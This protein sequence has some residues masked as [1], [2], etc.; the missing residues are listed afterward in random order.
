V[1]LPT[2]AQLISLP[3]SLSG[4]RI[5]LRPYR[6]GDGRELFEAID[7]SRA[8]LTR[9]MTWPNDLRTLED[10][11]ARV[12]ILRAKWDLRED[13]ALSLRSRSTGAILGGTG[14]HRFDWTIR[15]F[16]IGY[17][18]RAD[19]ERKGYVQEACRLQ[20]ALAFRRLDATHVRVHCDARNERSAA[21]PRAMGF[22]EE[23][24]L[25]AHTLSVEGELR[26]TFVFGIT[27]D[28]F[29]AKDWAPAALACVD[30]ADHD[31]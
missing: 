3:S 22:R 9:Y 24:R 11:E 29:E 21:V 10:T 26:D 23:A 20:A 2:Q 8:H 7:G 12:R 27:R 18:V 25:R 28:E 4:E 31:G 16:E 13:L 17:W 15:S 30:A 6:R 5:L 1:P 14:M 19:A